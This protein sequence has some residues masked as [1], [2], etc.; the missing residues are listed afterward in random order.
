[1]DEE[2]IEEGSRTLRDGHGGCEGELVTHKDEVLELE[3]LRKDE[4]SAY[5]KLP[6]GEKS[7]M[8]L[9]YA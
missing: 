3:Q 2:G 7:V 5:Y 8:R 9:R 1:M 6:A 4:Q